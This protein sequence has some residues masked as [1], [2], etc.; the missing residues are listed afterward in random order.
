MLVRERTEEPW[1]LFVR[2]H[3]TVEVTRC[4]WAA[5][6]LFLVVLIFVIWNSGTPAS[7]DHIC[8][9]LC[10]LYFSLCQQLATRWALDEW[11]SP[12]L[13]VVLWCW[14]DEIVPADTLNKQRPVLSAVH[15]THMDENSWKDGF[16]T[17][18]Q[19]LCC[20]PRLQLADPCIIHCSWG[21]VAHTIPFCDEWHYLK[22][23][24]L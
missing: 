2:K 23:I 21:N 10:H 22:L 13:I 16:A 4:L 17:W 14:L 3:S 24:V 7:P 5:D 9:L 12:Y 6:V 20:Q 8:L 19:C 15:W 1:K 18:G 11:H